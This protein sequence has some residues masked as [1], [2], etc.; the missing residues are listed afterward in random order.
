MR[1]GCEAAVETTLMPHNSKSFAA[2]G[3]MGLGEAAKVG[4]GEMASSLRF[5]L[6]LEEI[7]LEVLKGHHGPTVI[8]PSFVREG[9]EELG[10]HEKFEKFA[11]IPDR[12]RKTDT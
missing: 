9:N 4:R 8:S 3:G 7:F 2:Y 12:L 6:G 10:L 1:P 11:L 5:L